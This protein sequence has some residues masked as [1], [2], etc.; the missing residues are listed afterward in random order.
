M[1]SYIIS[2]L[3][4]LVIIFSLFGFVDDVNRTKVTR[5]QGRSSCRF[6]LTDGY[7][8]KRPVRGFITRE[9]YPGDKSGIADVVVNIKKQFQINPDIGIF[10]ANDEGNCYATTLDGRRVL[11]VDHSF[12]NKVN[13][14]AGTQWAAI[15]VLA[16]EIGHHIAGFGWHKNVVDEE[17]DADYWS[18]FALQKLGA[19]RSAAIKCIMK[20]GSVQDSNSHPNKYKRAKMIE[21]GWDDAEA[22][23]IDFSKCNGCEG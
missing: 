8:K 3:V 20:Y 21:H 10:L 15:S 22:G 11:I 5:Y 18:G 17:L 19:A 4:S 13:E 1:R 16:H 6:S 7:K 2:G 12:L 23:K 9:V 14:D